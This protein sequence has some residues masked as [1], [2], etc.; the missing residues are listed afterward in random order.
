MGATISTRLRLMRECESLSLQARIRTLAAEGMDV[1]S[2]VGGVPAHDPPKHV[3]DAAR[4]ACLDPAH[5][6]YTSTAGLP[7]LRSA[8]AEKM[9]ARS[10]AVTADGVVVANGAKQALAGSILTLTDP[11]DEVLISCPYWDSYAEAVALADATPVLVRADA[12]DGFKL[13]NEQLSEYCT[14]R[15]RGMI[16]ASPCNPTGTT[17]TD[18]EKEDVGR[19]AVDRGL[20]VI[21]DE[22]YEDFVYVEG[23]EASIGAVVP[24]LGGACVTVSGVSKSYGMTG[25]RVGWAAGAPSVVSAIGKLQSH[26][27]S[28]VNN[29]AQVAALAAVTGN[30]TIVADARRDC[31]QKRRLA[32]DVLSS[33]PGLSCVEPQ[34]GLY[35]FPCVEGYVGRRVGGV[36]VESSLG[37]ADVLLEKAGVAVLPGEAFGCPG[38][39]RISFGVAEEQLQEGLSRM[40]ECLNGR[41]GTARSQEAFVAGPSQ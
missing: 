27:T 7:E 25:W 11:G 37:L 33:T 28:H 13:T 8:I 41:E 18:E 22:I 15:T 16:F 10:L 2:L 9:R 24:E 1:V 35:A 38:Y 32:Y 21:A 29:V 20:W 3:L 34:G 12:R 26:V 40:T 17:Y 36:V 4:R 6:R 39:V 14:E 5:H 30:Q 31:D 19:W 23:S